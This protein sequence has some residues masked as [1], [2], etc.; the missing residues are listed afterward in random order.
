MA[1]APV[2][3]DQ[4]AGLGV[5]HAGDP[6]HEQPVA[7]PLELVIRPALPRL[8][9]LLIGDLRG[10]PRDQRP[11]DREERPHIGPSRTG[12]D[13][14]DEIAYAAHVAAGR[15]ASPATA[16]T[17]RTSVRS[18]SANAARRTAR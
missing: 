6:L 1:T 5:H 13:R 15:D 7:E 18:S 2:G 14:G 3:G 17:R 12:L 9:G 8:H 10:R 16:S 4:L 11:V